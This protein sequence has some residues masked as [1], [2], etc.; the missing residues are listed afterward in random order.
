MNSSMLRKGTTDD[1]CFEII[2]GEVLK[3]LHCVIVD[4]HKVYDKV[5]RCGTVLGS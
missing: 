5:P 3:A 4:L 2:D 1:I